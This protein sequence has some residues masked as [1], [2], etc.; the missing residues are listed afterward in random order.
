MCECLCVFACECLS[1]FC[2]SSNDYNNLCVL[3]VWQQ[4]VSICLS[5]ICIIV[6]TK[7]REFEHI[8][9]CTAICSSACCRIYFYLHMCETLTVV[10]G[11]ISR[12]I[13]F[14]KGFLWVLLSNRR[15]FNNSCVMHIKTQNT[16]TKTKVTRC[17]IQ[18]WHLYF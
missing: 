4:C 15:Q 2:T 18:L 1:M 8:K 14:Y 11:V 7:M 5:I 12:Y 13:L 10:E 9:M 17:V 3:N 6:C 16:V